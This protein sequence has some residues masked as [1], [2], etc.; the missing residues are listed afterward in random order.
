[1]FGIGKKKVPRKPMR[2]RMGDTNYL[3]K[4]SF[5][6]LSNA[7][8]IAKPTVRMIVYSSIVTTLIFGALLGIFTGSYVGVGFLVLLFTFVILI[9]FRFFYN[10][11]QKARQSLMT[12]SAIVGEP[13]SY[14]ESRALTKPVKST[15]RIMAFMDLLVK[16]ASSRRGQAEGIRGFIIDL[17]LSALVEVWDLLARFMLP[18]VVIE[19]K[20]IKDIIPELK[21][22][23]NNIPSTLV[24]VFGIDFSGDVVGGLLF[25]AYIFFFLVSVGLLFLVDSLTDAT[26]GRL[27]VS[28]IP[29]FVMVF[30]M[31]ILGGIL[32]KIMVSVKVI[33]FTVFYTSLK[34]PDAITNDLRPG[35]THY[36]NMEDFDAALETPS[37]LPEGL[38]SPEAP[39]APKTPSSRIEMNC[40]H[41]GHQLRIKRK[42]EGQKGACKHC[43]GTILVPVQEEP[44]PSPEVPEAPTSLAALNENA[45]LAEEASWE[46]VPPATPSATPAATPSDTP[47]ATPAAAGAAGAPSMAG[48]AEAANESQG[49]GCLFWL[50][51]FFVPPAAF[52]WGLLLPKEHPQRKVAII[53]PSV[54]TFIA[55]FLLVP[56]AGTALRFFNAIDPKVYATPETGLYHADGCS[57]VPPD[58][59]R[60]RA[61]TL[62]DKGYEPCAIC[63][64][65]VYDGSFEMSFGTPEEPLGAADTLADDMWNDVPIYP[66]MTLEDEPNGPAAG[67]YPLAGSYDITSASGTPP[68]SYTEVRAFYERELKAAGWESA[69][70][71][72][73]VG[74]MWYDNKGEV[75]ACEKGRNGLNLWL[76]LEP[77]QSEDDP[78]LVFIVVGPVK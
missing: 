73:G 18:A 13:I 8:D 25:L 41:C 27:P 6:V 70:T 24:G 35:L 68:D 58:A 46:A 16:Y 37:A 49:L 66:G 51:T 48:L 4:H 31:A 59:E 43:K 28:Y 38:A 12:Y 65:P 19:K 52:I 14:K 44:A 21:S 23:K 63:D 20:G 45:V 33:Y 32:K 17:L 30:V 76:L 53:V 69:M 11:R 34:W 74:G 5:S 47:P 2:E 64:P 57:E 72:T 36:L 22:L 39:V 10:M 15:L 62:A 40:P 60:V 42:Y 78:P 75:F 7:K 77:D 61:H 1:M 9:P 50:T 29:I 56:V 54:V 71:A 55:L 26:I 3:I 67:L